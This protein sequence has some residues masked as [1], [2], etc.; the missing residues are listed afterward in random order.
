MSENAGK[1]EKIIR[2]RSTKW[3]LTKIQPCT[4]YHSLWYLWNNLNQNQHAVFY[5]QC[6]KWIHIKCNNIDMLNM[7]LFKKSQIIINN[8]FV[9]NSTSNSPAL[10]FTLESDEVLLGLN[11]ISLPS[12]VFSLPSFK[13]SSTLTNFPTCLIMIKMKI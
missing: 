6:D 9:L 2:Y 10:L 7:K 8:G 13:L 5:D 1:L 3:K 4:M 11:G 12:V